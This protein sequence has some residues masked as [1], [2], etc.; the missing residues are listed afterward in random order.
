MKPERGNGHENADEPGQEPRERKGN[1][2][3]QAEP[4]HQYRVGVAA[5][6]EK[7][8]VSEARLPGVPG[9]HHE[10]HPGNGPDEDIG[11]LTDQKVV[12]Q[13]RE[14]LRASATRMP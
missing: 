3:G 10:P 6:G 2:K 9:Q 14:Q 7:R 8:G 1:E 11:G 13:E 5:G 4:L 12:H